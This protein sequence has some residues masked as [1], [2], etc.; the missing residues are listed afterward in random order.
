MT[1]LR[2]KAIAAVEARIGRDPMT[3]GEA[4]DALLA[5]GM[6][7]DPEECARTYSLI[8]ELIATG[9]DDDAERAYRLAVK[10]WR[11][12]RDAAGQE[13]TDA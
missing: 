4:V 9:K 6:L 11:R 5:A 7:T 13:D 10:A 12:A 2:D 1:T 3:P 8:S